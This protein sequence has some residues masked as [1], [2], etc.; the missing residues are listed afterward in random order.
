MATLTNDKKGTIVVSA[1]RARANFGKLMRL[2]CR[3][4][5]LTYVAQTFMWRS[6]QDARRRALCRERAPHN[7]EQRPKIV[8]LPMGNRRALV[9]NCVATLRDDQSGD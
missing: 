2:C 1:L 5:K 9:L 3:Q 7:W 8:G 4:H 6:P